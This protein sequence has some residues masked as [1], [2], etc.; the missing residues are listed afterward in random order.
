MS[1]TS[2]LKRGVLLFGSF[3]IAFIVAS[4]LHELCHSI[5]A[6]ITGASSTGIYIH[7]FSYS[8]SFSSSP[9]QIAHLASGAIGESFIGLIIFLLTFRTKKDWI[10]P[11]ILVCPIAFLDNGIYYFIDTLFKAGGDATQLIYHGIPLFA[12]YSIAMVL[13]MG[14]ILTGYIV[15]TKTGLLLGKLRDRIIVLGIGTGIY[16]L[17]AFAWNISFNKHQIPLWSAYAGC[18]LFIL[19]IITCIRFNQN[20]R[21][22]FA[23]KWPNAIIIAISAIIITAA[24][25]IFQPVAPLGNYSVIEERPENFPDI[26]IEPD[27][28]NDITYNTMGNTN[29]Y[30]I[31]YT[32]PDE[33]YI[34]KIKHFPERLTQ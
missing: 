28:S 17:S 14:G 4:L 31:S 21:S 32:I 23:V 2:P 13:V 6:F 24:L 34:R 10:L 19:G 26:L 8:Y 16:I 12:I 1:E 5:V 27:F 9:N 7:P 25:L 33:T 15:I 22:A 11:V 30:I 3:V 20:N 18:E 29:S